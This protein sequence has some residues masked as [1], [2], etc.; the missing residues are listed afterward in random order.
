MKVF[1]P[2]V[3]QTLYLNNFYY[4]KVVF[5]VLSI[6]F[7]KHSV[8]LAFGISE[9]RDEKPICFLRVVPKNSEIL[10]LMTKG[11]DQVFFE[12]RRDD[13]SKAKAYFP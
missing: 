11:T 13:A 1:I 7:A 12:T 4:F 2:I 3:L 6:L 8:F 9:K 10:F 5:G